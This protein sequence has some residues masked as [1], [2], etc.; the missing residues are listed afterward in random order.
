MRFREK[1]IADSVVERIQAISQAIDSGTKVQ[2][3]VREQ[4][5]RGPDGKMTGMTK[6]MADGTQEHMD[7]G[8]NGREIPQGFSEV[9]LENAGG[10][11]ELP[12]L[13]ESGLD[14]GTILSGGNS[15]DAILKA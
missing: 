15:I 2:A 4:I 5:V 10:F 6:T 12:G 7:I 13:D 9:T 3:P 1:H 11:T 14:A 8:D